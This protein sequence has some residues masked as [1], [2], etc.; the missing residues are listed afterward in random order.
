MAGE[1]GSGEGELL[2]RVET[3]V[4]LDLEA[5]G[6]RDALGDFVAQAHGAVSDGAQEVGRRGFKCRMPGYVDQSL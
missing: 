3:G 5:I 6:L 1:H 4:E 2:F